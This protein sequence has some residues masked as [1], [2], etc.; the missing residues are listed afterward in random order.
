MVLPHTKRLLLQT[1]SVSCSRVIPNEP[2]ERTQKFDPSTSKTAVSSDLSS[3]RIFLNSRERSFAPLSEETPMMHVP[4]FVT[5]G[6]FVISKVDLWVPVIF[7][8][9]LQCMVSTA[10]RIVTPLHGTSSY[11]LNNLVCKNIFHILHTL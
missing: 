2:D 1:K 9:P 3:A 11:I 8:W 6:S 5:S 4:V 10:F 7:G